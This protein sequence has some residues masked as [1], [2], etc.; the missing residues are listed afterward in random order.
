[1]T[2]IR[3]G[4]R[5]FLAGL[6][7]AAGGL[8]VEGLGLEAGDAFAATPGSP[9]FSPNVFVHI[10]PDGEVTLVCHRSEM[11]QGVRSSLPVLLADELGADM[12][13]VKISQADGDAV[14]GDQNTDGS[15]SVRGHYD[16][17]R[18]IAATARTMLVNA[19]AKRW[20]VKPDS[21]VARQH[22][23]EHTASGRSMGFGELV[24]LAKREPIPKPETVR[25][26][27][28]VELEHVGKELPH[29]DAK[30]FVTGAAPFGADVRVPG[31]LVAVIAR[32]PVVGGRVLGFDREAALA[33]RGVRH[34]VQLPEPKKPYVFQSWG[35]VAVIADDTWAALKGRAA[36]A[37]RWEH[38]ENASYDSEKYRDT[39]KA[40]ARAPG[41][42]LRQLGDAPA[43]LASAARTVE[44]E[45]YLPHLPHAPMEPPVALAHVAGGRC[46]VWAA[47]QN[48][49]AA[50][51]EAAR[52]LGMDEKDVA[53]HVTFLGGGFGRKSKADFVSE[54]VLLSREVN[55]PVR[56]QWTREDDVRHDY[57]H[58]VS[59]QR[60]VAG[61]GADGKV[62]AWHHRSAFPPIGSLFGSA[63]RPTAG[64]FQQGVLDLALDVPNVLSEACEAPAHVRIG[65]LRSVYNIFHSF[66]SNC[67]ID[68]IAHA[69]GADPRAVMLEVF[70]PARRIA[71][72]DELGVKELRNYGGSLTEYPVDV[73]RLR[74][75]V[76]RVTEISGWSQREK[77]G[78]SLGLAAH[79]SFHS[80]VAVVA[81]VAQ[82]PNGKL[83]VDEAWVAI[84]AGKILNPDRVRAQMEGSVIFGMSLAFHGAITMREG[85]TVQ[86]NF[87][88]YR[89]VRIGDAPR[90]IH[91]HIEPSE[92]LSGGAGEP[93][94][95]PVAPAIA[96]AVFALTGKRVRD[97]PLNLAFDV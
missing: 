42:A 44:A 81:S 93:G 10:A 27:P 2:G 38:G 92:E 65:W 91:V 67:F 29:L 76:E 43:A 70:G 79:R 37:V 18:R 59:Q 39:L 4:R 75:V 49:Q 73:G 45:Y 78:R 56:V 61:L 7:L 63:P 96:N 94:V 48:P 82:A 89:L 84:D 31:M 8:A 25:L 69:R 34:V 13:R 88:D 80:Y 90:A 87:R 58:T 23:V 6:G 33:V 11:G 57:Y 51:R 14:Y 55:A 97:L 41:T 36:L 16:S 66:A 60:L 3:L 12:A 47:T 85:A 30:A 21:L 86:S 53:V 83:A 62:V 24:A 95:P 46:E 22:R 54:A 17:T 72:P 64:D 20:G 35:G 26:R 15:S 52:A 28:D 1:M 40:S 32:P 71:T 74:G 50:R 9:S 68:E 19:A 77:K 5:P